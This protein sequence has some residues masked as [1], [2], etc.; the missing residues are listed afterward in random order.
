MTKLDLYLN[1]ALNAV[2]GRMAEADALMREFG[3]AIRDVAG[4][5]NARQP[6][7]PASLHRGVLLDPELPLKTDPR[8]TFV[9][10][11]T[12]RDVARWFAQPQSIISTPLAESNPR[13]RG[14]V[15]TLDARPRVLFHHAWAGFL[16]LPMLA[17]MHPA[18]GD[19]ASLQIAWSLRT[20]HEVITEAPNEWPAPARIEDVDGPSH[21]ELD[22]RLSPPWLWEGAY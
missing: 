17:R 19:D 13:L 3:P 22:R 12:D 11:S 9:S 21:V 1:F 8:Y 18:M 20:Q 6:S 4:A 5:F 14:F 16:P 2:L 15:V 10:W 7:M